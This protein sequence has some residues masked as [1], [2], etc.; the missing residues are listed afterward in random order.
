MYSP[1]SALT[2]G[3]EPPQINKLRFA[4][5]GRSALLSRVGVSDIEKN[6]EIGILA[7]A[8]TEAFRHAAVADW[9]GLSWLIG[10]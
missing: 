1:A 10:R 5:R 2:P 7:D 3:H 4:E 9:Q 6:R 8:I